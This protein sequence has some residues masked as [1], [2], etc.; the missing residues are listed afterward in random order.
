MA[1]SL[2]D[3]RD[4]QR[5]LDGNVERTPTLTSHTL[6]AIPETRIEVIGL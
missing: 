6:S 4:A 1:V 3:I 5:L 2:G